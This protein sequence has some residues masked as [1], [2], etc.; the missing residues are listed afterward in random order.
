MFASGKIFQWFFSPFLMLSL[1]SEKKRRK[2]KKLESWSKIFK[3]FSYSHIKYIHCVIELEEFHRNLLK[4]VALCICQRNMLSQVSSLLHFCCLGIPSL[5]IRTSDVAHCIIRYI[6]ISV[7]AN[8]KVTEFP[9]GC[10]TL[11]AQT[12]KNICKSCIMVAV[13]DQ[14]YWHR[15]ILVLNCSFSFLC[16]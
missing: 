4:C 14:S 9:I 1:T 15:I 6:F 7:S 8:S 3:M 12:Q 2:G 5:S 16:L 13:C 11:S 10:K